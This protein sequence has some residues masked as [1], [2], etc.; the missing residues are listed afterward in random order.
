MK[1]FEDHQL[2][3]IKESIRQLHFRTPFRT[4]LFYRCP[5]RVEDDEY[6]SYDRSHLAQLGYTVWEILEQIP[7][8][9]LNA[10]SWEMGVC[11][12]ELIF[13]ADGF[14]GRT[15]AAINSLSLVSGA[16]CEATA[17]QS[18]PQH[19]NDLFLSERSVHL[20]P[21][22]MVSSFAWTGIQSIQQLGYLSAFLYQQSEVLQHL[23][24]GLLDWMK[25][26]EDWAGHKS[27]FSTGD[28]QPT[29]NLFAALVFPEAKRRPL[30]SLRC[31]TMDRVSLGGDDIF[32]L[33]RV[34]LYDQSPGSDLTTNRVLVEYL[35]FLSLQVLKLRNTHSDRFL[36]F[37]SKQISD[38]PLEKFEYNQ[39]VYDK[40]VEDVLPHTLHRFKRLKHL[41]IKA[42]INWNYVRADPSTLTGLER[43][44]IDIPDDV[45]WMADRCFSTSHAFDMYL[46]SKSLDCLAIGEE[47]FLVVSRYV[48]S[49]YSLD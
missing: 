16:T 39:D 44:I 37:L 1:K 29:T 18:L 15:Q 10:F 4:D 2:D 31:L 47:P 43:L 11:L 23:E 46:E 32:A 30:T 7:E 13:G 24:I 9:S 36:R 33:Q 17:K 8:N 42:G 19:R 41:H 40:T 22:R 26:S 35:N 38:L 27:Y 12:P 48:P 20:S 3:R 6:E 49:L 14:L 28:V 5:D 45:G 21:F 34:G 25:I